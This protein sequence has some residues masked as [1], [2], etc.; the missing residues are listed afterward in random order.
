MQRWDTVLDLGLAGAESYRR[1]SDSLRCPVQPAAKL[2]RAEF[3]QIRTFLAS[4][5]GCL[6]DRYGLDWWELISLEFHARIEQWLRFRKLAEEISSC[7]EAC[8]SRGGSERSAIAA[9]LGRSV[10]SFSPAVTPVRRLQHYAR[11]L[12]T[13]SGSQLL[14][15]LGD[16]YDSGYKLRRLFTARGK[17]GIDPVVLLPSSYVNASRTALQYAQMLPQSKFLLV[18]TRR[19]GQIADLPRNAKAAR[20]ASYAPGEFDLNEFRSLLE[21]WHQLKQEL[22]RSEPLGRMLGA[23]VFEALEA[24]LRQGLMIRDAWLQVFNRESV[25]AVLCAD[26]VNLPTRV[27]LKIASARGLPAISCHHGALDGR[28]HMRAHP[29]GLF[30]AKGRMEQNYLVSV[31]RT[32]PAAIELG[33][34]GGIPSR[35]DASTGNKI[36]FFSEPYE[37]VGG[38]ALEFYRDVLPPLAQIAANHGREFVIKLHPAERERERHVFAR[39][40]LS[41]QQPSHPPRFLT[42]PLTEELL[43]NTWFAVSVLSTSAMECTLSG[44]PAFLCGWLDY[45]SYGYL[46]Q[47]TKF[48][49]AMRLDSPHDL[50]QIPNWLER[51]P[52]TVPCGLRDPINP[53]RLERLLSGQGERIAAAV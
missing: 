48:G 51:A 47:M 15:I 28:Y 18:A 4:G 33:A 6:L 46:A 45:S 30:L 2:A 9:L 40:A 32:D 20:L 13:F 31:C 24:T 42:G 29:D 22:Q 50:L 5:L 49:A 21:Q 23:G 14:Q 8:I 35:P 19:N 16:K 43:R 26:D 1:W 37:S 25:R 17:P 53:D 12:S 27:P 36:V 41:R 11:L 39:A 44:I 38:R 10:A 34:P 3:D 52:G 7:D